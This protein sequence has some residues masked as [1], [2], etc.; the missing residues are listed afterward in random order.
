MS[1]NLRKVKYLWMPMLSFMLLSV[2]FVRNVAAIPTIYVSPSVA[3][4]RLG[5]TFE[6][7]VM[8]DYAIYVYAWQVSITWTVG[9]VNL[10]AW[11]WG[12]YLRSVAGPLGTSP[13]S[14]SDKINNGW[15]LIGE[16][17]KGD[18]FRTGGGVL[19]TLTFE[20]LSP[21]TTSLYI[22]T[23]ETGELTYLLN[24]PLLN[25]IA[26]AKQSGEYVVPWAE[27]VN[28]I[29]D[30]LID[31]FDIAS[32][33]LNWQK[34]VIQTKNPT[35]TSGGWTSGSN[36]YTSDNAYASSATNGAT[37]IYGGY[38]FSTASWPS[39]VKVEIGLE[40]HSDGND[41]VII[42]ISNDGGASWSSTT[43][44]V[45][46]NGIVD[47]TFEWYD[48]TAAYSWTPVD[49]ADIA[50]KI[51]HA[52]SGGS[53]E[54]IYVDWLPVRVTPPNTAWNVY[55]DVTGDGVIDIFDLRADGLVFGQQY[56]GI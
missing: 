28:E 8:V 10:T 32:I 19:C 22:G 23:A 54:T 9:V 44:T 18:Y 50:V 3:T 37:E 42:A 48:F 34:F 40:F 21:G 5:Q 13:Y 1:N 15:F 36:A 43:V 38:G 17:L 41:D 35:T 55:T 30:G 29:P 31:I 47:D 24:Y 56:A 6:V 4:A 49:V 11:E 2:F 33:G 26:T 25:E 27:D 14:R 7:Q 51:T 45:E 39:V 12:D 16:G 46:T 52:K 53:A 20:V